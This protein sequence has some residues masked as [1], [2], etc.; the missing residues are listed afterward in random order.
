MPSEVTICNRAL[1]AIASRESIASLTELSTAVR[2]CNLIYA[3]MRDE[4]LNM[5]FWNFA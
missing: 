3:D 1:A 5:V 4:V 2:Q